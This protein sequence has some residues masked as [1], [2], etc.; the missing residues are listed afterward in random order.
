MAAAIGVG[1]DGG[2]SVVLRERAE[3]GEEH[4]ERVRGARGAAG[5]LQVVEEA[6]REAGGGGN[7]PLPT[8]ARRKATGR[9]RWWT[10]PASYSAGPVGGISY[11]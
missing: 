11:V 5:R 6:S 8:G 7:T 9:R 4:R 1:G 3:E 2:V 10:G